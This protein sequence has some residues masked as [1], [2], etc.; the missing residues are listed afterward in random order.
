MF[1]YNEK[2]YLSL[3]LPVA[4]CLLIYNISLNRFKLVKKEEIKK[5]DKVTLSS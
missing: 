1:D 4:F 5:E 2:G 3:P